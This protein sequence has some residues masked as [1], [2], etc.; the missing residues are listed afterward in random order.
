MTFKKS[1]VSYWKGKKRPSPSKETRKKMSIIR[2]G[3]T[4]EELYGIERAKEIKRKTSKSN[5]LK[6]KSN[7]QLAIN[8]SIRM[9][10]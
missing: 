2:K 10:V 3:K 1:N 9:R 6:Y 7:S 5:I 8:H 4:W